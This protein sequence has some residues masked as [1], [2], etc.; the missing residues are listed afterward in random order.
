MEKFLSG[1]ISFCNG[2]ISGVAP[3]ISRWG[4]DSSYEEAKIW[5][6]GYYKCQKSPKNCFLPS[7]GGLACSDGGAVAP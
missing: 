5:F 7:D 6:L 3:G 4:A 1:N 2:V